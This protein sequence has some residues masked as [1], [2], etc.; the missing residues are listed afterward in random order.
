MVTSESVFVTEPRHAE[1]LTTGALDDS[2]L[3][4]A[5]PPPTNATAPAVVAMPLHSF[6]TLLTVSFL[7]AIKVLSREFRAR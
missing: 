7:R 5:I 2:A 3:A 4:M 1:Y 6:M